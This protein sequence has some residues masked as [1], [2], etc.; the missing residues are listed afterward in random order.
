MSTAVVLF[1][2]DLR[3]HD[4]PALA[5]AARTYAHV[6]PLFVLDDA[7]LRGLD[8]PNRVAFLLDALDDLRG[9]L[10]ERGADLVVRRG[11]P[12]AEALRIARSVGAQTLYVGGDASAHAQARERRLER[13][14]R[15][16]RVDLR[17]VNT[18][19]IVP[20]RAVV[21]AG[22]DHYRVFTPVLA[23]LAGVAGARRPSRAG[24]RSSCHRVSSRA[25][26]RRSVR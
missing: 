23:P 8:A 5:E 2:R 4:Q 15:A 13:E 1:T 25:S 7:I 12:V 17:V 20:P 18:V 6:V 24:T 19:A 14:C 11:D 3:V 10:R 26:C 21:P 22:R 16:E 9:S